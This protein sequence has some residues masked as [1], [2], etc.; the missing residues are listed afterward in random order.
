MTQEKIN[1]KEEK[2]TN[3]QNEFSN[4]SEIINQNKKNQSKIL[5]KILDSSQISNKEI[6]Q[7]KQG[8]LSEL[9]HFYHNDKTIK[10]KLQL[11]QDKNGNYNFKFHEQKEK[12]EIP[13][14]INKKKLT[15]NDKEALKNGQYIFIDDDL[16]TQMKIDQETNSF[17]FKSNKE[18]Q[19]P[20][21]V[22]G[23][24]LT[25]EDKLRLSNGKQLP[26]KVFHDKK[27]NQYWIANYK[28]DNAT[29]TIEFKNAQPITKK[30]AHELRKR[31]N[32]P[33]NG[34]EYEI[35]NLKDLN[36]N[37]SKVHLN[38]T[39]SMILNNMDKDYLYDRED[40]GEMIKNHYQQHPEK[41]FNDSK[42]FQIENTQTTAQLLNNNS[43]LKI[44]GREEYNIRQNLEPNQGEQTVKME[45]MPINLTTDKNNTQ[46]INQQ[47]NK[48][49]TQQ[50]YS[51]EN[52]LKHEPSMVP[53]ETAIQ[54]KDYKK[55]AEFAQ[56]KDNNQLSNSETS[57]I[58]HHK[59]LNVGEKQNMLASGNV[60][61]PKEHIPE[62]EIEEDKS[63][64]L[65]DPQ[66]KKQEKKQE[67]NQ[68]KEKRKQEADKAKK[69]VEK[70]ANTLADGIGS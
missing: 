55:I 50:D 20:D 29:N 36:E 31:L 17:V 21:K 51:K 4:I 45:K 67:K 11:I 43:R 60:N 59:Q 57:Y 6:E 14:K 52:A 24:N 62:K 70:A 7:M 25:K 66:S 2:Q 39:D 30:E 61:N 54:N 26:S 46:Q 44:Q 69:G 8:K 33:Q 9:K 68:K 34:N 65:D 38:A 13:K 5:Q 32:E 35:S 10:G 23:Y 12:I 41:N 58:A 19:I 16:N 3:L 40:I 37:I 18:L 28:Q 48:Q 53:L 64:I 1:Q 56:E 22:A 42:K 49:H 63:N 15:Q 47:N 27:T